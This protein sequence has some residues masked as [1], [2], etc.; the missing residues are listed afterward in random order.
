MSI[1]SQFTRLRLHGMNRS[2]QALTE[3]RTHLDLSLND[4][5]ELLLQAETEDRANRR[6][7]RLTKNARFR[8]QATIE[9]LH[10]DAAK[11]MDKALIS[12][13]AT[14]DYL[15]GGES[16]L[17]CGATGCGKSFL[18][19]ALG[20]QACR[21]GYKV[22]YF[23]LQKLLIKIK[24]ARIEGTI[25]KFFEKMA[26]TDLLILDDFGLT[27][28]GQQH[29][30]D[31]M[32]LTED[33]HGRKST[34]IASQLPV[35]SWYDIFAEETIADAILDRLIHTSHRIELTGESLRKKL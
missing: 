16:I 4:G 28:L 35:G 18:A 15:S 26:K 23:N 25:L 29:C 21:Q 34:I 6:F 2:W 33:R 7:Q 22:A 20:H 24:M 31:L 12:R 10:M 14:G 11:G 30:L 5:L 32:E 13:L 27:H 17:I 9:E 3:T 8:Y 19:S 1:E